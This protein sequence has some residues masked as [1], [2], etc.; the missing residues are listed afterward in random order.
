MKVIYAVSS[1]SY[2]DY[3]ICG[4]FSTKEKAEAFMAAVEDSDYNEIEE[5][6]LDP[7]AAELLR[8][9]YSVWRVL[10]LKDG[11]V[12]KAKATG[13]DRYDIGVA[14][15]CKVWQ[16]SKAPAYRGTG[17]PDV[18]DVHCWARTERQAVKMANEKRVEM[19]AT[20]KWK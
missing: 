7:S 15:T 9:G 3:H 20:G 19:I 5:Y 18:L 2:S 16:R 8:R 17:T 13:N 12:E 14:G 4:V 6:E 10:M 1:G 11:A